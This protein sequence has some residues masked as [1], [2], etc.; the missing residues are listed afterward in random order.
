MLNPQKHIRPTSQY[1]TTHPYSHA[2]PDHYALSTS[3]SVSMS[4]IDLRDKSAQVKLLHSYIHTSISPF[5][6]PLRPSRYPY[7]NLAKYG[8]NISSPTYIPSLPQLT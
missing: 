6:H 4:V 5:H 1:K 8:I 3:T 7:L 2:L